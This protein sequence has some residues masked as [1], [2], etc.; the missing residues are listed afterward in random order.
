MAMTFREYQAIYKN[1][2]VSTES[3][4]DMKYLYEDERLSTTEIAQVFQNRISNKT[5]AR[6]LLKY[7]I[8]ARNNKG[9]NNPSWT[10]GRKI[11]KG[12]Y[13]LIHKPTHPHANSQGY[14]SEHRL[15]MEQHLKR[16][17]L[18]EELVHHINKNRQD[19]RIENLQ[20]MK[21]NSAH[22]KLESNFRKRDRLG[23]YV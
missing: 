3:I 17:L 15:E 13:I 21:N 9:H 12:G 16:Y 6:R 10:G 14:V 18:L 4:E 1:K 5:I 11:G 8:Q 23:R 2:L 7:G 19:N 22:A 20:L